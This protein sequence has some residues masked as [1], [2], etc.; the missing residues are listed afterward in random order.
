MLNN[1]LPKGVC[2]NHRGELAVMVPSADIQNPRFALR[3]RVRREAARHKE[4]GEVIFSVGA[5]GSSAASLIG[6]W[7]PN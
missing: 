5:F 1:E 6:G 7:S 4:W 2:R 3:G